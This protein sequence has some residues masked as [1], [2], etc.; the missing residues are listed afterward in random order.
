MGVDAVGRL[1]GEHAD[2]LDDAVHLFE[3]PFGRLYHGH[4]VLGVPLGLPEALDLR[5]HFF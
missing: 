2:P 5:A 3:V 1:D 4:A